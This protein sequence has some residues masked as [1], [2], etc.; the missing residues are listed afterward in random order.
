MA[1]IIK[2]LSICICIFVH[3][4]SYNLLE[5]GQTLSSMDVTSMPEVPSVPSMLL[6]FYIVLRLHNMKKLDLKNRLWLSPIY[7]LFLYILTQAAM[8]LMWYPGCTIISDIIQW[9]FRTEIPYIIELMFLGILLY[10]PVK[11]YFMPTELTYEQIAMLTMSC[12]LPGP[13]DLTQNK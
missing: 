1:S 8:F 6:L 3:L 4:L 11:E 2:Y 10:K 12:H 13:R 9:A 5:K 7:I